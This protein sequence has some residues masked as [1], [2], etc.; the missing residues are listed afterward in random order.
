MVRLGAWGSVYEAR[1]AAGYLAAA[2]FHVHVRG[3]A[4]VSLRGEL[5]HPETYPEVWV[6]A[7]EL[8]GA[9]AA[10]AELARDAAACEGVRRCAQCGEDNP[11]NFELCWQCQADLPRLSAV[12]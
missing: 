10:L 9:R 1:L 4:L 7:P 5:P 12:R 3:E 6:A 8:A 11:G 2:G